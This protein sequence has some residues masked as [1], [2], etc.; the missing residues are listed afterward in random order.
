MTAA[1]PHLVFDRVG[2]TRG[3]RRVFEGFSLALSERRVGLVGPNGSG[4]STLLRL[5]HG[6]TRADAGVVTTLGLDA[7]REAK[8]LPARVGFLFQSPDRQIVFPTVEEEVA[9]S[10][11]VGGASRRAARDRARERLAAWRRADWAGRAI[12]D[13][14]EGE[15]QLVC[16]IAVM[17]R[18]PGLL[19]L[20]EPF[21]S[22]DLSARAVFAARLD[23]LGVPLVMASHDLDLLADFERVV[24]IEAGAVR[25][26]GAPASVLP[27]YREACLRRAREAAP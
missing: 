9:F 13:L 7:A 19:L 17:A 11:E 27:A 23:A 24:W 15:K 12:H 18:D 10:F 25:G 16:L 14:S 4:K 22:L 26:D 8:A 3:T 1:A 6:L 5:A 21:A 2:V 20:D